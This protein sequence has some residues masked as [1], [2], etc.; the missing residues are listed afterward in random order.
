MNLQL[1]KEWRGNKERK[2]NVLDLPPGATED[3]SYLVRY[4]SYVIEQVW[5]HS[6]NESLHRLRGPALIF[7]D[8]EE[9]WFRHDEPYKPT[10]HE[11]MLWEQRKKN[12]CS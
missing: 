9:R 1:T 3:E 12:E 10:A 4:F 11:R 8:G 7:K 2:M 6:G 5:R